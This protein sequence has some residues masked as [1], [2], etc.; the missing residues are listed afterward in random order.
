VNHPPRLL[1]IPLTPLHHELLGSYLHRLAEANHLTIQALAHEI[2]PGRYHARDTESLS[3]WTPRTVS[4]LAALTGTG[5]AALLRA[6]PVLQK[7][8]S[9]V[10][11]P[12]AAPPGA[13]TA[14]R[15]THAC[16][17]C[18]ARHGVIG[19]AIVRAFPHQRICLR[20]SRWHGGGD[21]RMLWPLLPETLQ[22]N[23]RHRR[24]VRQHALPAISQDHLHAQTLT[25]QWLTRNGPPELQRRWQRRLDLLG[26][27]TYGDPNRP[28][29]DRIELVTYPET[30]TLTSLIASKHTT[31]GGFLTEA[32]RR[33]GIDSITL[34]GPPGTNG[35][36]H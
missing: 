9:Q 11:N 15:H 31:P 17:L 4:R 6:L 22:A 25:R 33:L 3:G 24:L 1:P 8:T 7:I 36:L 28:G 5:T 29:T 19:M 35:N 2:G 23:Q 18:A 34:P 27:D 13:I 12:P 32:A 16:R 10:L 14:S 26:E 30:V 21:Q 20:H